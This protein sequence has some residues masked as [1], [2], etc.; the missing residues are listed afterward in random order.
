MLARPWRETQTRIV[1]LP[2]DDPDLFKIFA[3]FI[4]T[5]KIFSPRPNDIEV[6]PDNSRRDLEWARLAH[7]WVLGDKV[8]AM[9][10]KD[11]ITD[12]ICAKIALDRK[13]PITLHQI[14]YPG[15][16]AAAEGIRRLC[17]NIARENWT[18]LTLKMTL[19]D[20]AWSEFFEDLAV[21][22][23]EVVNGRGEKAV[24][25]RPGCVYHEHCEGTECWMDM[26][27]LWGGGRRPYVACSMLM[28]SY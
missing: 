5:G 22:L 6:Y 12:A 8:Q 18:P 9:A 11:A 27:F 25:G 7:A 19:R 21:V 20:E 4:Y 14:I 15:T 26:E 24:A 10:F 23:M 28:S 2:E 1:N 17:V 13:W 3:L 16:T